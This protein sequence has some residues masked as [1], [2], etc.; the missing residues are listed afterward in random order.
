M[1]I[2][3]ILSLAVSL[4]M[5]QACNKQQEQEV[6]D[7]RDAVTGVVELQPVQ[8]QMAGL[9]VGVMQRRNMG[10]KIETNGYID[11]PPQSRATVSPLMEGF[12][13]ST[14]LLEGDQVKKGQTL[15]IL[16]HPGYIT[17][18]QEYLE[19]MQQLN[20]LKSEYDRQVELD[21]EKINAKKNLIRAETDY[22]G[23][24]ARME[25]LCQ[26]LLMLGLSPTSIAQ[27]KI[28]AQIRLTSPIDGYIT[29]VNGSL[30]KLIT[31]GEAVF[32]IVNL[33]HVHIEM[34][35]FE[36]DIHRINIG[37]AFSFS[38]AGSVETY[39]GKVHLVGKE[40][41]EQERVVHVHG[42]PDQVKATLLPGMYVTV[43]IYAEADTVWV[44]PEASVIQDDEKSFVFIKQQE[45]SFSKVPVKAGKTMDGWIEIVPNERLKPQD[46]IVVHGTYYLSAASS[47]G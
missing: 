11:V 12:I 40:L 30:G 42:H 46:S 18:Q 4:F 39:S 26:R 14:S 19:W 2:H 22:K 17:L 10:N 24:L 36:E 47:D 1:N 27:G 31:P 37:Q 21:K 20:F 38:L 5:L 41:D 34:K 15:A 33:D 9:A 13:K 43:T 16:E 44:L 8:L 25:A 35:V 29:R 28:Y 7:E 6:R 3:I 32:E 23:A 45:N